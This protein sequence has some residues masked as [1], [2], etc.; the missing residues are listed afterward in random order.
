MDARDTH[1]AVLGAFQTAGLDAGVMVWAPE[2]RSAA[3]PMVGSDDGTASTA[4]S[5]AAAA[6]SPAACGT[7]RCADVHFRT[8]L[9]NKG[10]KKI[11]K[12]HKKRGE[13]TKS[14]AFNR[15][16]KYVFNCFMTKVINH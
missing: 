7:A 5:A 8:D 10:L 3:A 16:Y 14:L 15:I 4:V 6:S 2:E 11:Y 13:P 1:T 12:H 9:Q